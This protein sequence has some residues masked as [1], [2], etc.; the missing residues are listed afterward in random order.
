MAKN[1]HW[2]NDGDKQ[3]MLGNQTWRNES[4]TMSKTPTIA[5][6]KHVK[7]L[8]VKAETL[9]VLEGNCQKKRLKCRNRCSEQNFICPRNKD[10]SL[11]VRPH[12]TKKLLYS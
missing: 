7:D 2:R 3:M 10:N 12:N 1:I 11:K 8:S 9:K 4:G 6:S 5:N